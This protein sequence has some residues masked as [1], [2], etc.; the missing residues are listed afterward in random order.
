VGDLAG[1]VLGALGNLSDRCSAPRPVPGSVVDMISLFW[2]YGE[3]FAVFNSPTA[4]R[5][6]GA[7]CCSG[8]DR[9]QRDGS[10]AVKNEC[11]RSL[12]VPDGLDGMRLDQAVSPAVRAVRTAAASLVEAATRWSTAIAAQ[13]DKV[14][15]GSCSRS[16]CPRPVTAPVV[17]AERSPA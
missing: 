16:P 7:G 3:H 2:P 4:A 15:A 14:S 13:S 1:L 17:V 6:R 12:P 11:Q 10:R 9:P 5:R 8:A